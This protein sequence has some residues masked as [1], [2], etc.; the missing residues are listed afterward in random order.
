M[1]E[2]SMPDILRHFSNLEDPR[3]YNRRH[4]LFD[5]VVITICAVICGADDWAAVEEFG[6]AKKA[7]LQQ[8]LQLPHGIPSQHTFRRVFARLDPAR[9]QACFM[10]WVSSIRAAAQGQTVAIDGKTLRRSHDRALGKEA[11]R[12]VSAWAS[13]ERLVLGQVKVDEE[14][15]EIAA[16]PQLLDMLELKGAVVTADAMNCQRVIV[17]QAVAKGADY[18]L[19][20]KENQ[21]GL[22]DALRELFQ[23]AEQTGFSDCDH[24]HRAD[25]GHGRIEMRD[26][27]TTS[28]PDYLLYIPDRG[29]WAGLRTLAWVRTECWRGSER[30]EGLTCYISSLDASAEQVLSAV[31]GHWGI[32]NDLH[33]SLD[34]AFR[35][36]DSRLRKGNGASN[37]A[38]V[39]RLA[40]SLLKRERTAKCGVKAKRLRAGW[41]QDYLLKVL[42]G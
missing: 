25:K 42:T 6:L 22:Y 17:E 24:A 41:D 31:R 39:R 23:Y 14:S 36:D 33:W 2:I 35:E 8:F 4:P 32:E 1:Q 26:C 16:V 12:L 10:E 5:I 37:L 13:E 34:V 40:L 28:S 29:K 3:R 9:F 30:T 21:R 19:S 38:L 20:V 7:W 15:N 27:W 18:V 11:L